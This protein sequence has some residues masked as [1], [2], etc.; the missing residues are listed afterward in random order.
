[1]L[2]LT[3]TQVE[4]KA[5]RW[6][7]K[8][9]VIDQDPAEGATLREGSTITIEVSSG[10]AGVETSTEPSASEIPSQKVKFCILA[11]SPTLRLNCFA[12][13]A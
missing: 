6:V 4:E 2:R 1:M 7:Q 3:Q 10:S 12:A 13:F 11:V 5:D 8:G 9:Y